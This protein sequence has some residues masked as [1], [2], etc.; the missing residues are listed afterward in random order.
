[1]IDEAGIDLV[2]GHSSHHPLG[3]EVYKNKLILYGAGDFFNDYEG[4]SGQEEYRGELGLMYFPELD[5]DTGDLI[6]LRLVPMEIKKFSL[7]YAEEQDLEW[8][9]TVLSREGQQFGTRLERSTED[10]LQLEW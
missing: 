5:L 2:F 7:N 4:I 9:Q 3:I 1:L 6:S 8:L 10:S